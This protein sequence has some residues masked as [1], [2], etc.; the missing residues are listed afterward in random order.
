VAM[1]VYH[2]TGSRVRAVLLGTL[3]GFAEPFGALLASL[4]ANDHSSKG[5]FGGMF[6]LTAG[7]MTYAT[8]PPAV[9]LFLLRISPLIYRAHAACF[10]GP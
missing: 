10:L 6:G 7:M 2:G 8:A 4:V 9:L 3:S 5:A 1:P